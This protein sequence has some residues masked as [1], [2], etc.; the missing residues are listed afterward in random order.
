MKDMSKQECEA[1]AAA[2]RKLHMELGRRLHA[3]RV[4]IQRTMGT[5]AFLEALRTAKPIEDDNG[6]R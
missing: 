4:E 2:E 5:A 6:G 3:S 1:A